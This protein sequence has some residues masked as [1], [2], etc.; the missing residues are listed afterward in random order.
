MTVTPAKPVAKGP[1]T[2]WRRPVV[3][4]LCDRPAER[5]PRRQ[6]GVALAMLVPGLS[7]KCRQSGLAG[8]S[9]C[10]SERP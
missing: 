3:D 2:A 8:C 1:D 4:R 10:S 5:A 6:D 9:S 7:D